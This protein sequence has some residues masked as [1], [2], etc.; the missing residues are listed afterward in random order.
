MISELARQKEVYANRVWIYAQNRS[1]N[2]QNSD[3]KELAEIGKRYS[4]TEILIKKE[5]MK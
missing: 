1:M 3:L 4:Y 5:V 2:E